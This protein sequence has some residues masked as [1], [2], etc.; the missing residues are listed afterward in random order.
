MCGGL[1]CRNVL[2]LLLLLLLG[3]LV[4]AGE[5]VPKRRH[6]HKIWRAKDGRVEIRCRDG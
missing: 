2:L 6:D 1:L 3:R 5:G 4:A